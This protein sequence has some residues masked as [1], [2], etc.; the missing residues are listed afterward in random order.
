MGEKILFEMRVSSD[1][2]GLHVEIN[3]SPEWRAYHRPRRGRF[4]WVGCGGDEDQEPGA[5]IKRPAA[6]DLRRALDS[7]QNIYDD[8]YS[9]PAE[10]G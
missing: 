8:L 4:A 2:T 5:R 7:L 6:H 9:S 10:T 1:E 3:A